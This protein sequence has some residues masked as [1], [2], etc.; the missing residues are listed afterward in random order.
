MRKVPAIKLGKGYLIYNNNV[1]FRI[2]TVWW[3]LSYYLL[4]FTVKQRDE[5]FLLLWEW[6]IDILSAL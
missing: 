5:D 6:K 3:D 1:V 4:N 2:P